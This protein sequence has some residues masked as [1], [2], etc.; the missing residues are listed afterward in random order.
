MNRTKLKNYAPQAR[1]D[2]I[3]AMTD[4]A[5]FYGLTAKRIEP[6]V[7][8]GDVAVI[9]GQVHPRSVAKRRKHLEDRIQRHGFEQTMEA[10]AYTWFNRLAALR[11]MELH[12]YLDHG[13]RALSHREGKPTPEVLEHA[14][15]VE[16]PGLKKETVVDLKL[17]GNKDSELYRRLLTAQCNALNKAMP[18]LF[19]KIDDET[20]LLLPDNLLH[21]DSLIRK[22]VNE[23]D[24][25]DWQEGEIN[26]CG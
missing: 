1:R 23:I 18:F 5:A 7:E 19:E 26:R 15:H 8:R 2:F 20:E 25:E 12:G 3:Q 11:F 21:S 16:L 14:D 13:Y 17:A 24:G 10:L 9:A 6:V 4:R 22:L